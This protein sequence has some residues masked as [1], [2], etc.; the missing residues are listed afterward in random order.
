MWSKFNVRVR[1]MYIDLACVSIL[2]TFN[3]TLYLLK[4]WPEIDLTHVSIPKTFGGIFV[5]F[6]TLAQNRIPTIDLRSSNGY[7]K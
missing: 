7:K 5:S 4:I 1:V 6:K 2:K 3:E